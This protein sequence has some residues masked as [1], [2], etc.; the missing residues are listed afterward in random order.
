M[1]GGGD[2]V[3]NISLAFKDLPFFGIKLM[4][5][6]EDRRVNSFEDDLNILEGDRELTLFDIIQRLKGRAGLQVNLSF[7]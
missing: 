1:K 7:L 6:V 4:R 5:D 3:E 2:L